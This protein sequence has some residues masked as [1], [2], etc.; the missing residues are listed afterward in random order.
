MTKKKQPY[1]A[2]LGPVLE[3]IGGKWK[4]LL[5]WELRDQPVRFGELR[6]RMPGISEKML[7]QQLRELEADGLVHR[8]VFHQVPPRVEYS[9]TPLGASLNKALTPLC[10]W[11]ERHAKASAGGAKG[12]GNK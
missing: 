3:M 12:Q 2:G 10:A 9:V 8:E 4:G 7:I 11:G 1:S 5:L 6:R